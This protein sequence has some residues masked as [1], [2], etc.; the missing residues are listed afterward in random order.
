M[1]KKTVV[2]GFASKA[3]VIAADLIDNRLGLISGAKAIDEYAS[4]QTSS[5]QSELEKVREENERLKAELKSEIEQAES[6]DYRIEDHEKAIQRIK[7]QAEEIERLRGALD[8]IKKGVSQMRDEAKNMLSPDGRFGQRAEDRNYGIESAAKL[9]L[10][11]ISLIEEKSLDN[12]K[13]N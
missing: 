11:M 5:L 12:Q 1:E 8:K 2:L 6:V 13:G 7:E 10:T 9:V 3:E 4:Q